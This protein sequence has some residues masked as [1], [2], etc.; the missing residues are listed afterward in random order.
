MERLSYKFSTIRQE[1]LLELTFELSRYICFETRLPN[2]VSY[3][4]S[5]IN[6][7]KSIMFMTNLNKLS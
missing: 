3:R 4:L 1:I 2:Q 7:T 6:L 5:Y